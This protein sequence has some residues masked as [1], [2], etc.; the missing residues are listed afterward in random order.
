MKSISNLCF[1]L[2]HF[3]EQ[4]SL[5]SH[6]T[7][8]VLESVPIFAFVWKRC[9]K[10]KHN[11]FK[12]CCFCWISNLTICCLFHELSHM[13]NGEF[14]S[15]HS[16]NLATLINHLH[17]EGRKR[18]PLAC[19]GHVEVVRMLTPPF[20]TIKLEVAL[21]QMTISDW[22]SHPCCEFCVNLCFVGVKMMLKVS[23]Q[24]FRKLHFLLHFQFRTLSPWP[25]VLW[26]CL[27]ISWAVWHSADLAT[28]IGSLWILLFDCEGT[29]V[30]LSHCI[31]IKNFAVDIFL[32]LFHPLDSFLGVGN[33]ALSSNSSSTTLL[34]INCYV[35]V[36][37]LARRV[38]IARCTD[39]QADHSI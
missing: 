17:V 21:L 16:L 13:V 32:Q 39:Q 1:C 14:Q 25:E 38:N 5:N 34:E 28:S 29:H 8:V 33:G 9:W 12:N 4:I 19:I 6:C 11:W 35:M 20:C 24:L 23:T 26:C 31:G 27:K 30:S 7:P 10:F 2:L 3:N 36:N 22:T 37:G 15:W 18:K